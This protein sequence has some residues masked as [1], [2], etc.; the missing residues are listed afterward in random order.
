MSVF[1]TGDCHS[2]V[3]RFS[4]INFYEQ[5]DFSGNKDE[6]V[7]VICGDFGLIW[8]SDK[9]SKSEKYWLDWLED[10]PFTTVFVDGNHECFTRLYQYPIKEWRGG[11][12]H[13]IRPHV[14]HLMRGEIFT[15]H[16][17]K[18][19][20]FGGAS[21]HDISD[22]LFDCED[23][24]WKDKAR[25][26]FKQGKR[27]IRIKGLSWWEQELPT[28]EEMQHG[29]EKLK[30]NDNRVDFIITHSPP[31]SVIALLGHGRY[32]QDVLTKYL[33]NIRSETEYKRWF[34]GHMHDDIAVNDKNI[35]IY[36]QIVQI[37]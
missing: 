7:V 16:G 10:K 12:V 37:L 21:S 30:D 2:D 36:E 3:R 25:I 26:L 5:R 27:M 4:T 20:A 8:E 9:E 24:E 33:E 17:Y 23:P 6:N 14:L 29:L 19:F 35:L 31:A 22:A 34:F 32:K 11:K 18:F 1:V 13:E 28:K 15:I